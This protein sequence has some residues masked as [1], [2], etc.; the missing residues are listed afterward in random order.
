MC[1]LTQ[2]C[3]DAAVS[4]APSSLRQ[5]TVAR[6]R[7]LFSDGEDFR[8]L[9]SVRTGFF[10]T[11]IFSADG[12]EQITGFH[13]A[14]DLL[15]LD[16]MGSGQHTV[17]AVALEGCEVSVFPFDNVAG[18][19]LAIPHV[20]ERLHAL[21]GEEIRRD[22]R[23]LLMLGNRDAHARL[24][25]FLIDLLARLHALG[26]SGSEAILRMSRKDIGSHLGLTLE[27]VSRTLSDLATKGILL[28]ELR[29]ITVVDAGRLARIA[30]GG[31]GEAGPGTP[32]ATPCSPD[33]GPGV[34]ARQGAGA[35]AGAS[36]QC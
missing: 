34:R 23:L 33:A 9:Y 16:G 5:R 1:A 20:H 32:R 17:S 13:M 29:H 28:V 7:F 10:K 12:R 11:S 3:A 2:L 36:V 35:G 14:G 31:I 4:M 26:W 24:A 21:L 30:E 18:E 27:T 22:H 15:G 19:L 6:G 8:N 25:A